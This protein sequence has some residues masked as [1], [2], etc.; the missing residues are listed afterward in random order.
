ML[1]TCVRE[2]IEGIL[3]ADLPWEAF[4]GKRI[5][6]TG[7]AGFLPSYFVETLLALHEHGEGA[8]EVV[9]LV[10]NLARARRRFAHHA[11]R[12]DFRLIDDDLS[13]PLVCR[14]KFN[15]IIHAA[16][17]ASPRFY[18]TDPVGTLIP[19]ML[20]TYYLLERARADGCRGFLFLSSGDVYGDVASNDP[21]VE[22]RYGRLDPTAVRSCYGESKRMAETL[23]VCMH[24]QY[25]LAT[26]IGRL[27]HTYGPGLAAND[28]RVFADFVQDIAHWR[29]LVVK[30]DGS[31]GRAFCYVSDAIRGLF[32]ILLKGR[33]ARPYN[34]GNDEACV[35]IAELA[36][37]L[38]EA[39]PE[40]SLRVVFDASKRGASY[41]KSPFTCSYPNV[42]ALR[43]LGWR[44]RV[45]IA[46]GFRRT[47]RFV[48]EELK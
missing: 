13:R 25:G 21:I 39:F 38:V 37:T 31:A 14:G 47:L 46:E 41:V 26:Y 36:K 30:S 10:R 19:N 7:A 3:T 20:G 34:V 24:H 8:S 29:D 16:S 35:T 48:E 11:D 1:T 23:C 18:D 17:Q 5:L 45:G 15:Y 28:G 44:P 43:G 33:P 12:H 6:V 4:S 42:S 2:D 32:T 9:G 40:R 22:S 27:F